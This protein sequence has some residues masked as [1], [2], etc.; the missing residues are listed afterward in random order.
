MSM[1][2][3]KIFQEIIS[4][5]KSQTARFVKRKLKQNKRPTEKGVAVGQKS[6]MF[7]VR[8]S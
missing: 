3:F 5:P 1:G 2:Y 8:C 7:Y 6:F 4:I